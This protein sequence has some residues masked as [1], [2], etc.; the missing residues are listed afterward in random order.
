MGEIADCVSVVQWHNP[1]CDSLAF[2]NNNSGSS[3]TVNKNVLSMLRKE[4]RKCLI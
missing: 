4:G 3:V 2:S 1:V